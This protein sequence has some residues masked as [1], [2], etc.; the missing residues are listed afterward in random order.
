MQLLPV[1]YV[2]H[3]FRPQFCIPPYWPTILKS[4][5]VKQEI[6]RQ[7]LL[8]RQPQRVRLLNRRLRPNRLYRLILSL[9]RSLNPHLSPSLSLN[10]SLSRNLN[11]SRNP[12]RNQSPNSPR[13]SNPSLTTTSL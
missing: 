11:L 1:Y 5:S 8:I 12:N 3:S 9:C 13:S 10:L 2:R 6:C 7:P 4:R